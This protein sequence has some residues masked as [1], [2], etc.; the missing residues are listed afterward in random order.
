MVLFTF[1]VFRNSRTKALSQ[2]LHSKVKFGVA[3]TT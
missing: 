2:L 3:D 1:L